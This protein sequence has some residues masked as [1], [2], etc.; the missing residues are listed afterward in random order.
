MR[1]GGA[2]SRGAWT[3]RGDAVDFGPVGI[4][5]FPPAVARHATLHDPAR[6]LREAEVRR[7]VLNRHTPSP[8][9]GD[10][11]YG[12][13][14]RLACALDESD[15][16][17]CVRAGVAE[18]GEV[19]LGGEASAAHPGVRAPGCAAEAGR[20]VAPCPAWVSCGCGGCRSGRPRPRCS[21][22]P[23]PCR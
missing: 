13:T 8:A 6:V 20:A 11:T 7:R 2:G 19:E 1:C 14:A 23:P 18:A 21:G 17:D 3:A 4:T 22:G 5:G 15:R 10:T 12:F 16:G 9:E